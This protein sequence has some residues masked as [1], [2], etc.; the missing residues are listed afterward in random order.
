MCYIH[1]SDPCVVEY[2][3]SAGFCY[4]QRNYAAGGNWPSLVAGPQAVVK[5]N[6]QK[7]YLII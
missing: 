1:L 3:N 6:L 7:S 5:W 2:Q 4:A